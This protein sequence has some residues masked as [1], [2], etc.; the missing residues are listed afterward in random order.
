[1]ALFLLTILV[2]VAARLIV[3]RMGHITGDAAL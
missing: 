1:V 2:N 3:A